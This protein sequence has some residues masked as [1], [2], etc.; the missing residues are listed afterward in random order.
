MV[1]LGFGTDACGAL[2][3]EELVLTEFTTRTQWFTPRE[4]IKQATSE[5]TRILS[6]SGQGNPYMA[7][8]LGVI[9][10]VPIPTY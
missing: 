9:K 8:K 5:N 2:G 3:I 6:L 1:P 10:K 7:G 4:I